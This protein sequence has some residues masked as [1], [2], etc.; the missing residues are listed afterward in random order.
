MG[1]GRTG[2]ARRRLKKS[3]PN[4]PR[5]TRPPAVNFLRICSMPNCGVSAFRAAASAAPHLPS[6]S[7]RA[8]RRSGCCPGFTI[9][10]PSRVAAISEAGSRA[11]RTGIPRASTASSRISTTAGGQ[12]D[13][14]RSPLVSPLLYLVSESATGHSFGRYLDIGRDISAQSPA[15][16]SRPYATALGGGADAENRLGHGPAS[17]RRT[18]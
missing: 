9:S 10:P 16:L 8:W 15:Q 14:G 7:S 17:T 6:D 3:L 13:R 5:P 12:E 2:N 18:A 1:Q 11:G 4:G